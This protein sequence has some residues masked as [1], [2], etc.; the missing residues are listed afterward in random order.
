MTPRGIYLLPSLFTAGNLSAGFLSVIFSINGGYTQAAWAIMIAILFDI[1]DGR[2]ARWTNTTSSFGVE[3]DSLADLL[4]FGVA[5][6]ILM[7]QM[8]LHSLHRVGIM[9]AL[10]YVLAGAL[11]LARFNVKSMHDE[12][13]SEF[14]GLP[15]PAAAGMLA[16][17][18][19]SYELFV[20]GQEG[21]VRRYIPIVMDKMPFFMKMIP[22]FM[23][24]TAFLMISTVPYIA[25]K[26]FKMD[27]PKS[28][29]V[30]TLI[31]IAI[32]LIITY[33]QNTIFIM[34]LGYLLSGIAGYLWRYW[35]LRRSIL[36]TYRQKKNGTQQ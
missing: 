13:S 35:R 36:L 14:T 9:I 21:F 1:A 31:L 8:M 32:F 10:F 19:L 20:T 34:F 11:R 25:L 12:P 29:Q 4:S 17:F 2:I 7:Y 30:V 16:S 3:F 15:I 28:L 22:L 24:L 18:A 27:R 26:K 5:P 33:P 6:A 23:V